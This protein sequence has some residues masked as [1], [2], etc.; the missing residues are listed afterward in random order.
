MNGFLNV[1]LAAGFLQQ[2][3]KLK[4][5]RELL[6]DKREDNF[7]FNEDGVLWRQKYFISTSQ[8]KNLRS[9]G[10]ISFGSCSFVEPIDDL[11]EIGIL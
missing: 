11:K 2:R 1:F 3:F 7:L 4:L 5:I 10:A 6:M 9:R 8:L